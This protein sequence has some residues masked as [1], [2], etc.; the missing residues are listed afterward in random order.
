MNKKQDPNLALELLEQRIDALVQVCQSLHDENKTLKTQH[1]DLVK[2]R[3]ALIEKTE[4][5]KA[6]VEGMISR[7]KMMEF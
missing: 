2:Q 1:T 6:R 7:L 3:T 5:A 4:N